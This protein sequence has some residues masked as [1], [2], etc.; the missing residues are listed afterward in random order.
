MDLEDGERLA[1]HLPQQVHQVLRYR[2]I[3]VQQTLQIQFLR[4]QVSRYTNY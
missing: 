2:S 1:D 4:H 3:L